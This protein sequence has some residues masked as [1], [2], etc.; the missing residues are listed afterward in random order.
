VKV[1]LNNSDKERIAH[2]LFLTI[3]ISLVLFVVY[4]DEG[5]NTFE[6]LF[7]VE[8]LS[9]ALIWATF[10]FGLQAAPFHLTEKILRFPFRI[11]LSVGFLLSLIGA[12]FLAIS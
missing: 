10:I 11:V 2:R 6:G 7:S 3:A 8:A 4:I 9:G 5:R 1:I 12:F